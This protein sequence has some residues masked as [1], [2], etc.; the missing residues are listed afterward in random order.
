MPA[1]TCQAP[2]FHKPSDNLHMNK[3]PNDAVRILIYWILDKEHSST[4]GHFCGFYGAGLLF[5][6]HEG[7]PALRLVLRSPFAVCRR[8]AD[9]G[10]G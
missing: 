4:T 1:T 9:A 5:V 3:E 7:R 8:H 2:R 6:L 10:V